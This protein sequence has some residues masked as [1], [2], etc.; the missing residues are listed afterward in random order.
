MS[1]AKP[2]HQINSFDIDG[3]IF[4]GQYDGVYPNRR[5]IIITGRS[6]EEMR[7]TLAMLNDKHIQNHV[8]FNPISFNNKTR[9]SSGRHKGNTIKKLRES[10]L[11]IGLHFEDDPIQIE[12]ILKIVPDQKIVYLQHDLVP[13][14]NVSHADY[15][16]QI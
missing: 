9:E 3:V 5:D 14:E 1:Q 6:V 8:Y 13:K 4:M 15:K 11:E 16:S 7:E 12:E 10:G 2:K